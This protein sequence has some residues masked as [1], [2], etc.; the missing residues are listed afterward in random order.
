MD[1]PW[2][3]SVELG[4]RLAALP[5]RQRK[6][7]LRIVQ[8]EGDCVA[9]TRLL[10]TPYS[11]RW[12][13]W[14]AGQSGMRRD[15][16]KGLL[17]RHEA[18]CDLRGEPW[19]FVCSQSIYYRKWT[20]DA[21]FVGALEAARQELTAQAIASAV[22]G[23]QAGTSEAV[24]E[25]RRLIREG[26]AENTRL[27]AAFGLLDRAGMETAPKSSQVVEGY[28]DVTEGELDAIEGALRREAE[29]G[30]QEE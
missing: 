8:A 13:G 5:A 14:V 4:A 23:L 6:A 26:E 2:V 29:G 15:V 9:L 1:Y 19:R 18:D 21:A 11:C 28:V 3:P 7:V 30:G 16:R 25:V 22:V 20:H 27:R 17:E 10:K 24:G 12:C